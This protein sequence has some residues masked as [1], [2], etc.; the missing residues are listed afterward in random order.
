[1]QGIRLLFLLF[2]S[3][4]THADEKA[5]YVGEGRYACDRDS[6]ECAVLKQRSQEQTR[7]AQERDEDE[8]RYERSERREAEYQREYETGNY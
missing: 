8:R 1:M 2:L 4:S 6:V 7:R 3:M 5:V